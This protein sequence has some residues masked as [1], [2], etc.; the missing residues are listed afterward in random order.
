M[1]FK[2]SYLACM[3]VCYLVLFNSCSK[4][5]EQSDAT[6]ALKSMP[7]TGTVTA[8]YNDSPTGEDIAKVVDN[9]INTKY[10]TFHSTGWL[11]WN[12]SAAFISNTY[13][14]TSANDAADRDPKNWILYGSNDGTNWTSLDSQSNQTFSAR[15]QKKSYAFTNTTAYIYYKLDITANNGS[16][17]LQLAEWDMVSAG[18]V[19]VYQ[20]INY[21][22]YA[23]VLDEGSYTQAALLTLGVANND[24]TSLKVLSG[25]KVTLYDGDNFTGTAI[26]KTADD[27]SL[28]DDNFN[29]LASSIKVE[30]ISA[31]ENIDDLMGLAV[32]FT[33]S[34]STPMGT[35]YQGRH[36]TTASDLT[37]LSTAS[38]EPPVPP[39]LTSSLHWASFAVTLYP[40][41]TPVP[42]DINQHNIGDCNGITAL[43]S[44]SYLAPAFVK[45]LIK[46]NLDGTYNVAMFDPQGQP[47][48]VA[49]DSKFLADGSGNLAA[50]S[51]KN[52]KADWATILEKCVMKYNVIYH[53][54]DN[55]EGIGSENVTPLFTGVGSS[56]AFNRN[57]LTPDQLARVVR[58]SLAHGKFISGGFGSVLPI[59]NVQ[60][61]TGHG[62]AVMLSSDPS[63]LFAMRNPWGVNP[64]IAGGYDSGTDGV[65]NIPLTGSVPATIDVRIIDPGLA[66]TTGVTTPY[67]PPVQTLK[68]A[69][70]VRISERLVSSGK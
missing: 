51:A 69:T 47:I 16:T 8:Q 62:Y 36:V 7:A 2:L 32:G 49:V 12:G 4:E 15:F 50:V 29:D 59:G 6:P 39:Q 53:A 58:V 44:M 57:V 67:V 45:N 66:G 42:A 1:K 38:N 25:Y 46:D 24:L 11:Q 63:A 48:T 18:G 33:A 37:Y 23:V 10:L 17:I 68:S 20:H 43:A 21:G 28:V 13:A 5:V 61:V 22:G 60:T 26:V 70:Q 54:D 40:Y 56:F 14:I 52:D 41:G 19:V 64:L 9:N 31:S 55:I 3:T 34:G 65:L 30:K 27:P 35:H